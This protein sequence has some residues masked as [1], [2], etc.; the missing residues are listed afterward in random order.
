MILLQPSGRSVFQI[1]LVPTVALLLGLPIPFSNLG[2]IIPELLNPTVDYSHLNG[3]SNGVTPS[4]LDSLRTNADQIHT[5]LITYTQ[6]SE[7]FPE[8]VFDNL[9]EKLA[10]LK[11]LHN[12]TSPQTTQE[13]LSAIAD[14]YVSYMREVK[15]MCHQVWAKF[16]DRLI[17]TGLLVVLLAVLSGFV[18][19]SKVQWWNSVVLCVVVC[20]VISIVFTSSL[21]DA[22]V[23]L[24]YCIGALNFA[25]LSHWVL[26]FICLYFVSS[27]KKL[28]VSLD[29]LSVL[30]LLLA[31]LHA[32]SLLSNSFVLYEGD[33]VLFFLQ[34]LI[35]CLALKHLYKVSVEEKG[36][37]MTTL[38]PY[39]ALSICLR[40]SKLFYSCRDLQYQDGCLDTTFTQPYV[41]A[42]EDLGA[43]INVRL[44]LSF[45]VVIL[46]PILFFKVALGS[47]FSKFVPVLSVGRFSLPIAGLCVVMHW[48]IQL[49]PANQL[50]YWHHVTLPWVVYIVCGVTLVMVVWRPTH[51]GVRGVKSGSITA[52]VIVV[53]V[54]CVWV[55]LT[56][57]LNDG[58]ALASGLIALQGGLA[59]RLLSEA[60]L[61]VC[62][63]LAVYFGSV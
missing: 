25:I 19:S 51:P 11:S 38:L 29:P 26:Q 53:M 30:S 59:V 9:V 2:M 61:C 40:L 60:G 22:L 43:L 44:L 35:F 17:F 55:P 50:S 15:E 16:D 14:G 58:L 39:I 18:L 33:M 54:M 32:F 56:M 37:L 34:T 21:E 5:Y 7:D 28:S 8:H 4:L 24:V 31:F 63:C 52:L 62:V 12:A 6:Y 23:N 49:L 47:V 1:D 20:A 36:E 3:Y 41:I 10:T 57:L 45:S 48:C 42:L 13:E 46:V 27:L